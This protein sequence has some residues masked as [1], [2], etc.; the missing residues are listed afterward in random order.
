MTKRM[1]KE[2]VAREGSSK[3]TIEFELSNGQT[4]DHPVGSTYPLR[5]AKKALLEFARTGARPQAIAW[6]SWV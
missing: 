2:L 5:D 3:E 6:Q 1:S 4:D